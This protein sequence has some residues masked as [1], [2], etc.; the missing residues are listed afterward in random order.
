MAKTEEEQYQEWKKSFGGNYIGKENKAAWRSNF[1]SNT[2]NQSALTNVFNPNSPPQYS[3][4]G[5]AA[6]QSGRIQG[7]ER[8]RSLTGQNPYE[9]GQDYQQAYG[10]IK[11]RTE[12]SDTGSELLRANK[13]GAVADAKN[14]LQAQGVK[15]GAAIGAVSQVERAK[16]YD[17]NNQLQQ[18]QRQAESD[19]LNATKAN[20]NFT[21][22]SE[23]N[24][25]QMALGKDIRAPNSN[26]GGMLG[27][28]ICTELYR[29][30]YYSTEIYIADVA[31][32]IWL[33]KIH[34]EVYVGYRSWADKLVPLM[35]K[36]NSFT[37]A[38]AIFAVPWAFHIAGKK[39]LFGKILSNVFEPICG[40]IGKVIIN[41]S[42]EKAYAICEKK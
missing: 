2:A 32:G 39:N 10:N 27:T 4:T 35:Q 14:T 23:M 29:Q 20:A 36:S 31:Y 13:A 26:S 9:I 22:A 19:Y 12:L 42:G 38:V 5:S 1:A 24:F 33:R 16:S 40:I 3:I 30:G 6:E 25:G 21:Q 28:V 15:G 17:V 41:S 37:K 34:P 8:A 18:N 11:K 7:L